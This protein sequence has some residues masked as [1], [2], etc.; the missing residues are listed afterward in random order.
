MSQKQSDAQLKKEGE[1]KKAKTT[2][3][4]HGIECEGTGQKSKAN[5]PVYNFNKMMRSGTC[6]F[7]PH[8]KVG[9]PGTAEDNPI[10]LSDEGDD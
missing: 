8:P 3:T 9:A 4:W 7:G 10:D 1:K 2:V 6:Y 5:V